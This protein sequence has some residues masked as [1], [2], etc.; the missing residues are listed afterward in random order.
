MYQRG[1]TPKPGLEGKANIIIRKMKL[2]PAKGH[3]KGET[4]DIM[5]G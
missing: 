4:R 5:G 1:I 3:N 2:S